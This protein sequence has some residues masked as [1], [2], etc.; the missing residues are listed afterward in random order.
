M[1][2]EVERKRKQDAKGASDQVDQASVEADS[3]VGR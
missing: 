2:Y 1:R 3:P